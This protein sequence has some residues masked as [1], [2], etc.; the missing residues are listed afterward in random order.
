MRLAYD[1]HLELYCFSLSLSFCYAYSF[2][3]YST[4]LFI[5]S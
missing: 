1:D 2:I 4:M 3:Y 5:M